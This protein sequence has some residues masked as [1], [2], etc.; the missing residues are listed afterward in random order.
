[1]LETESREITA[2]SGAGRGLFYFTRLPNG[3]TNASV[4]FHKGMDQLIKADWEPLVFVYLDDVIIV[5]ASFEEYLA[6]LGR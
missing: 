3:R 2:F 1:M 4:V 6:W 5:T